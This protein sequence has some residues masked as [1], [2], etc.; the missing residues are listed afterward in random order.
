VHLQ[1]AERGG[2]PSGLP[3]AAAASS[4]VRRLPRQARRGGASGGG[5]WT[6][7]GRL[8]RIV[9]AQVGGPPGGAGWGN[10]PTS[11]A[12]APQHFCVLTHLLCRLSDRLQVCD[13]HGELLICNRED[14]GGGGKVRRR[15][16]VGGSGSQRRVAASLLGRV[17]G[18]SGG[19]APA[20]EEPRQGVACH[21]LGRT[22]QAHRR[23]GGGGG[24]IS[25][26]RC[27]ERVDVG[28]G[29]V[30]A[31]GSGWPRVSRPEGRTRPARNRHAHASDGEGVRW[32]GAVCL[33]RGPRLRGTVPPSRSFTS[34][35][36]SQRFHVNDR[37]VEF[38][39]P[40]SEC[41]PLLRSRL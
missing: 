22:R 30:H 39:S 29:R 41:G 37:A 20:C 34:T 14:T 32:P 1:P 33:W 28:E 7:G 24:A 40:H 26:E 36:T 9:E 13:D 15:L 6:A 21:G 5:G 38:G 35:A 3:R 25:R 10:P 8:R 31:R 18:R 23:E 2:A 27:T 17:G 16:L 19:G 11:G 4:R 12:S